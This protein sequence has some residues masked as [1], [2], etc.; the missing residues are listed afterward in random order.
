MKKRFAAI[1]VSSIVAV[2]LAACGN[3]GA[4]ASQ[5]STAQS[6]QTSESRGN[7]SASSGSAVT[8]DEA[9]SLA[10]G[11]A[12]SG[13]S[14][15]LIVYFD[16]SENM[17]DT[18]NMSADAITS[19]SL[20]GQKYDGITKN[21]LLVMRDEIQKQT[22][23]DT[24]SVVVTDPYDPD[25]EKMV[26]VAQDD[27]NDNKKF[28]FVN[29]LPD[30]SGYDTIYMGMPVWWGGLPQPMVSFLDQNDFSGKTIIPFG[31]N[32]GSGFGQ[33]IDQIKKAEPNATVSD[34]GLTENSHTANDKV[35]SDVDAWLKSL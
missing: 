17:G 5:T 30:L 25:Y 27:Q 20:A 19:A 11:S 1:V 28:S 9:S 23:A 18:S 15:S 2:M 4:T 29:Q 8:A 26:G 21:D 16:Y 35:I 6:A 31:I 13:N 12:A 33:M 14:K 3:S 10:A 32:L 34:D 7:A 24:F 22:D